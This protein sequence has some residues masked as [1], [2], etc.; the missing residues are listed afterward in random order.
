MMTSFQETLKLRFKVL[1]FL[2]VYFAYI[3]YISKFVKRK[4][5]SRLL[6]QSDEHHLKLYKGNMS[7]WKY[8]HNRFIE[9][10]KKCCTR[11]LC[12]YNLTIAII[13]LI[14]SQFFIHNSKFWLDL[15][16][17]STYI[18][19]SSASRIYFYNRHRKKNMYKYNQHTKACKTVLLQGAYCFVPEFIISY[20]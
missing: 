10:C 3:I 12:H 19:L 15:F 5:A 6:R 16:C 8:I 18:T 11:R 4:K 7:A 1:Q 9:F 2:T 20:H 13:N 14:L 17:I